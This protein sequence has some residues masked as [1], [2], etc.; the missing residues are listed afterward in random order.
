[1]SKELL[2]SEAKCMLSSKQCIGQSGV[3]LYQGNGDSAIYLYCSR[4][5]TIRLL[6]EREV[7]YL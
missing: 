4:L 1:M 7:W 2:G 3:L 6:V 5:S